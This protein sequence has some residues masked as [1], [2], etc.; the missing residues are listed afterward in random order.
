MN[1]KLLGIKAIT[2]LHVGAGRGLGHIDLP[3]AREKTTNYPY[4]PGTALKGVLRD[5]YENAPNFAVA[6]GDKKGDGSDE[7]TAGSLIFAD[8]RLLA[9]PI[10]SFFGTF[11]AVS[12]PAIIKR[13]YVDLNAY[14]VK[15]DAPQIPSLKDAQIA[16]VTGSPLAKATPLAK[17][18]KVYLEDVDFDVVGNVDNLVKDIAQRFEN[19]GEAGLVKRFALVSDDAFAFLCETGTE[20]N[21]HIKIN[22]ETGIVQKGALWY[23]E[24]L[25]PETFLYSFVFCGKVYGTKIEAQDLL[26]YFCPTD[27][28]DY[29]QFG[30][31]ASTGLG[32]CQCRFKEA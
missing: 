12:C 5:K 2:S 11:A 14:G 32:R 13:L 1:V 29:L 3:I 27:K 25:P 28:D 30:G 24:T 15:V 23:Q 19:F 22:S 10:R 18:E 8:A 17:G 26:N 16:V 31:K 20:I 7:T 21:A 9:L 6:F 4:L